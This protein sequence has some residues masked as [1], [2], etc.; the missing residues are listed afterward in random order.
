MYIIIF[1]KI[2]QVLV[3]SMLGIVAPLGY[4][5]DNHELFHKRCLIVSNYIINSSFMIFAFMVSANEIFPI[6]VKENSNT[7]GNEGKLLYI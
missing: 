3:K 6:S 2:G 1:S 7:V 4:D 5:N